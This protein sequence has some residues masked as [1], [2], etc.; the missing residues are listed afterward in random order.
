MPPIK[1]CETKIFAFSFQNMIFS[2]NSSSRLGYFRLGILCLGTRWM[3]ATLTLKVCSIEAKLK[4][5]QLGFIG[6]KAHSAYQWKLQLWNVIQ[7][8]S[9]RQNC[10]FVMHK[11]GPN[12]K[13]LREKSFLTH[14]IMVKDYLAIGP[15]K[16]DLAKSCR[17]MVKLAG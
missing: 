10:L 3:W 1:F 5:K 14:K 6:Q 16:N 4:T 2:K 12:L 17:L 9:H 13:A 8:C 7:L 11:F 15:I